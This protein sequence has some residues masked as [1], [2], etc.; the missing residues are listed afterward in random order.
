MTEKEK[1]PFHSEEW[2]KAKAEYT[3]EVLERA[4][5]RQK[6]KNEMRDFLDEY[7]SVKPKELE[8]EISIKDIIE[9]VTPTPAEMLEMDAYKPRMHE[10]QQLLGLHS[11][12]RQI[13]SQETVTMGTTKGVISHHKSVCSGAMETITTLVQILRRSNKII[14]EL[15]QKPNMELVKDPV[16]PDLKKEENEK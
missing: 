7:L 10:S 13:L 15:K 3:P 14:E 4:A 12:A 8:N 9:E 5:K 1:G 6:E 16:F 2:E 11:Y